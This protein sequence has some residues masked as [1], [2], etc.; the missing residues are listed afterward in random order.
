MPDPDTS[1]ADPPSPPQSPSWGHSLPLAESTV[2]FADGALVSGS[3]ILPPEALG[4]SSEQL[5]QLYYAN[6]HPA[7][8]F[9]LPFHRLKQKLGAGL[10]TTLASVMQYIGSLYASAVPSE[11]LKEQAR[12]ACGTIPSQP[13]GYDVQALMLYGVALYWIDEPKDGLRFFDGAI[14]KALGMGMHRR[15]YALLHGSGDEVLQESWRRTWWSLYHIDFLFAAHKHMQPFRT[16]NIIT[17][18]DLP[19]EEHEYESGVISPPRTLFEYENR[20]FLD[21]DLTFSSFAHLIGLSRGIDKIIFGRSEA[22]ESLMSELSDNAD[23]F[24]VGWASLL[25]KCK[26]G[27][28]TKEGSV[29]DLILQAVLIMHTLTVALQRPLSGLVYSGA[30]S[31]SKCAPP[32]PPDRMSPE[33]ERESHVHTAKVLHAIEGFTHILTLP[34]KSSRLTPFTIC[35]VGSV[36]IANLS[37][38]RYILTEKRLSLARE[39]LRVSLG[40]LKSLEEIWP[41]GRTLLRELRAVA[42]DML[43][44]GNTNPVSSICDM[45]EYVAGPLLSLDCLSDLFSASDTSS[46]D[47]IDGQSN[48]LGH[49]ATIQV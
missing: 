36:A 24:L 4:A 11:P 18:V 12:E 26:R 34:T 48:A 3:S 2:P 25:P 49:S 27:A 47:Y 6:F 20:E 33:R 46:Y 44:L 38:C 29:D 7:H 22:D 43:N 5:L 1:V 41:L 16:S 13:S 9:A 10:V 23:T 42:R 32:A 37:A 19:C 21:D 17:D 45:P 30:E 39:R 14:D 8:P 31:L 35:M 40:V 15:E 28:I